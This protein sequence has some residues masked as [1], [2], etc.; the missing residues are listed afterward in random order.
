MLVSNIGRSLRQGPMVLQVPYGNPLDQF[1]AFLVHLLTPKG[2]KTT[3][4]CP[5]TPVF[6]LFHV[7]FWSPNHSESDH[8]D[9]KSTQEGPIGPPG[10]LRGPPGPVSSSFGPLWPQKDQKRTRFHFLSHSN[11]N[12]NYFDRDEMK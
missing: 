12:R 2:P 3:S 11:F 8:F 1:Q 4:F 6:A 10:T 5:K 7:K 9:L